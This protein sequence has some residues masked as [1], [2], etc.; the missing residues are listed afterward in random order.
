MNRAYR[1]D[2]FGTLL[3]VLRER[4]D[5]RRTTRVTLAFTEMQHV[6][7]SRGALWLPD[8]QEA[9]SLETQRG[10]VAVATTKRAARRSSSP[11][12]F[13]NHS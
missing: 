11:Y 3:P 6:D 2:F 12:R 9:R 13:E 4:L 8:V 10:C 5:R 7:A 1:I